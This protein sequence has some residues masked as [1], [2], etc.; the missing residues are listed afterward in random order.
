MKD[1]IIMY[2]T[3]ANADWKDS[4][5]VLPFR[6]LSVYGIWNMWTAA[7]RIS[8]SVWSRLR[9]SYGLQG[10]VWCPK[11][12]AQNINSDIDGMG[13]LIMKKYDLERF[14]IAQKRDFAEALGQVRAGRKTSHWIWYIF[15]Q[16][17][18]LGMSGMSDY[19]GIKSLEEAK[20]F[21]EDK[22]LRENLLQISSALL[23]LESQ[24]ANK[25]FGYPDNLKVCS[26][27][28]LFAHAA[29]QYPVFRDV[30]DKYYN[31]REDIQTLRLLGIM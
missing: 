5:P 13:D 9:I 1:G 10:E 26:C 12:S 8:G 6:D 18:G 24:S 14:I 31:G 29:P 2:E 7:E 19:Y 4:L 15:P 11:L 17:K 20:A 27:M 23:S 21:M 3:R 22:F 16:M 30:L 28:T 25:I